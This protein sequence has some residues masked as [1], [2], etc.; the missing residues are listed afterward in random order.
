MISA[1][2]NQKDSIPRLDKAAYTV[3]LF[4]VISFIGWCF[5]KTARYFV[6]NSTADRGFLTM[7]ICPIYGFSI[8]M[9]NLV[10]G[11]P[12]HLRFRVGRA[13]RDGIL[14]RLLNRALYCVFVCLLVT[15]TELATGFF[16]DRFIG[17]RL[18]DYSERP[19][20]IGGYICLGYSLLWG[21]LIC[22]FME[23]V[24][25]PLN[26]LVKKIP[27]R[28]AVVMAAVLLV[29][30]AGD[31]VFNCIFISVTGSHFDFL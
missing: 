28:I 29:L 17:V 15:F 11:T 30:A 14:S 1:N 19:L 4:F 13:D 10:A 31:F 20:N 9:V 3:L 22:A 5:E 21:L 2:N 25:Y 23:F 6:Y 27:G 8:L 16:F 7:P 24:W 12:L 18:W 26:S